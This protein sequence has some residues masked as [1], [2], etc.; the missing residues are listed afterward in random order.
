MPNKKRV[1]LFATLLLSLARIAAAEIFVRWDRDDIP[2]QPSLGITTVVVPAKNAAA[3]RNAV[4]RGY[5]VILEVE[6]SALATFLP[7][8]HPLAGIVVTGKTS[9]VEL[10]RVTRQLA[11]RG[12]RVLILEQ[13][14][15]PHIRTNWVTSSK[16]VLQATRSSQQPWIENNRAL[17]RI[18]GATPGA[19]R[20][21]TYTWQPITLSDQD[22]GPRI[23][24]YL[25]AIA[26]AG[27][28]G[29]DLVLPLHQRFEDRLL[30]GQPQARADW[31]EIGRYLKFYSSNFP[32]QY[33][34][35]AN[36]G[37]VTADP[38]LWFEVLNLLGRHNLAFVLIDPAELSKVPDSLKM[39]IVLDPLP[40]ARL[41]VLAGLTKKGGTLV[42]GG[43][44]GA[45]TAS[46]ASPPWH[47]G[48]PV[49]RNDQRASYRLGEGRVVEL[50]RPI[51]D[52]NAFALE[53]RQLLGREQRAVEIWN[54]IT[55]L[56]AP[57]REPGGENLLLTAL[58]Y[59]A[60]PQPIQL[61]I[62]GTFSLVQYESPDEPAALLPH[63][64]RD[65]YTE[66]VLPG[67]RAG[68]RVFLTR[69]P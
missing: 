27:S 22:E 41:E 34:P 11:S 3:V 21:L 40:P 55:C 59:A 49:N 52:P 29:A 6:G 31:D 62:P 25:V 23:E 7:P 13:G 45:A 14:K 64:Q 61:R 37:V 46:A 19:P 9:A 38:T 12:A 44:K 58:N 66:F 36:I 54:G 26:E 8:A 50:L 33:Q 60:D 69:V 65:G 47:S 53:M 35:V 32:A 43:L 15:W 28:F 63:Q 57:Y 68:G 2:A 17:I 20:A 51:A 1:V 56:L 39:L 5:R 16:G 10:N 30:L 67:L 4:A 24:N 42:L 18:M 48:E